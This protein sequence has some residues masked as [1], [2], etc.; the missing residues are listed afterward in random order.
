MGVA[1]ARRVSRLGRVTTS[2]S[3]VVRTRRTTQ[4]RMFSSTIVD[5][6]RSP[7]RRCPH[8]RV[9]RPWH[10]SETSKDAQPRLDIDGTTI[11][12]HE[13][14]SMPQRGRDCPFELGSTSITPGRTSTHCS[15]KHTVTGQRRRAAYR[16]SRGLGDLDVVKAVRARDDGAIEIYAVRNRSVDQGPSHPPRPM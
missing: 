12:K 8:Q 16:R 14:A 3:A 9:E 7:R 6:S 4:S 15:R 10:G 2:A 5:P 11:W 13:R 1:Y